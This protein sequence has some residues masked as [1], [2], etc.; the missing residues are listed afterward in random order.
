MI[1]S[2]DDSD[3]DEVEQNNDKSESDSE[4][5]DETKAVEEEEDSQTQSDD[6]T[7][8][9]LKSLLEDLSS[10]KPEDKS[11]TVSAEQCENHNEMDDVAALAESIQPK[12]NTLLTTSVRLYYLLY[13]YLLSINNSWSS[14]SIC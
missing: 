5:E 9:G 4:S 7:G 11:K 12:G 8:V 13:C 6:E 14:D 10:E 3:K 1:E 2:G